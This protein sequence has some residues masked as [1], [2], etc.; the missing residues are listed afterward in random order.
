MGAVVSTRMP[1]RRELRAGTE[2]R[3]EHSHAQKERDPGVRDRTRS[4]EIVRDRTRSYEIVDWTAP[5][6]TAINGN[7]SQ[8]ATYEIVDWTAPMRT[9][10]K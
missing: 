9:S 1:K 2:R 8:S 4:Y 10:R 3:G 7:Q 5:M 6:R